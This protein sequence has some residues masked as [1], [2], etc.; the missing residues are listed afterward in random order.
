MWTNY[1]ETVLDHFAN[2]RNAGKMQHPDAVGET[3]NPADGDR[4]LVYLRIQDTKLQ[5][6]RSQ[7]YGCAAA[8]A[9]TSMLTV[10]ATGKTI[11][12]AR[13]ITN[14][15]VARALGGLPIQKLTCS[16]IA[17]DALQNALDSYEATM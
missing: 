12:E 5:E 4:I 13:T 10:L 15:Q 1:N 9:A 17:A 14:D 8:I 16:N 7:T 2:P 6:V 11:E 3:G